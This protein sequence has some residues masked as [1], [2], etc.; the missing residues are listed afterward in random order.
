MK[1][2]REKRKKGK[3]GK[4]SGKNKREEKS[5]E[6]KKEKKRIFESV[7]PPVPVFMYYMYLL[8][9]C[10]FCSVLFIT[11]LCH[12]EKPLKY[13]SSSFINLKLL[14]FMGWEFK[15]VGQKG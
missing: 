11:N 7:V 14:R 1:K 10:Y 4:K 8:N 5:E 15:V 6:E 13:I 2:N 12:A 3:R 9:T